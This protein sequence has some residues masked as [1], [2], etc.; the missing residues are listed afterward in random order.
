MCF[1]TLCLMVAYAAA[2]PFSF[3][4]SKATK[5][6]AMTN[7]ILNSYKGGIAYNEDVKR[8]VKV[9]ESVCGCFIGLLCLSLNKVHSYNVNSRHFFIQKKEFCS[10]EWM[11]LDC[12]PTVSYTHLTLPTICSV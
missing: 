8:A 10:K 2:D 4:L 9:A 3:N 11:D 12:T 6:L 7:G 1:L 5:D